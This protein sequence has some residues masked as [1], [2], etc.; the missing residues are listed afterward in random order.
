MLQ[1]LYVSQLVG[2]EDPRRSVAD[3]EAAGI[4]RIFA[5]LGAAVTV[6]D[7]T[8]GPPPDPAAFDAVV[9]GGSFGSANDEEPWRAALREWLA[10]HRDIAL[11]GICGGHQLL[12]RALGGIVEV[13]PGPQ[14]GIFPLELR[15]VPGFGG[16]VV[17]LHRDRVAAP[18]EGAEVWAADGMG[19]QALRY[20]ALR[21]TTQ[22]HPEMDAS[23][24]AAAEPFDPDAE[25]WEGRDVAFE[26][27]RAL[28][29]AWLDAVR[30]AK[31]RRERV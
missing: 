9:V 2:P 30:A 20:G 22:F 28:L 11:F 21:W 12:A 13:A 8:A 3:V 1:L 7:A 26:G 25:A 31:L 4:P 19:V 24:L 10:T 29:R 16:C 5:A 18:P 6:H 27:G 23:L 17:Q 14:M 15:D